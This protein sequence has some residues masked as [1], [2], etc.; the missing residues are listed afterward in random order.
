[1]T[2]RIQRSRKKGSKLP[3]GTINCTR[4]GPFGNPFTV[5]LCRQAGYEGTDAELKSYCVDVFRMWLGPMWRV[6]CPTKKS[7]R[8]RNVILSRLHEIRDAPYACCWCREGDP[9]HV[10]VEIELAHKGEKS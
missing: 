6:V 9:C 7:E 2:Q 5:K 3:P 10:D 1:M 4:P 8:R